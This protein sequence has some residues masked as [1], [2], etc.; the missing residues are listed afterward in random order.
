MVRTCDGV[1]RL[2]VLHVPP[3]TFKSY[4]EKRLHA[5]RQATYQDDSKGNFEPG[6]RVRWDLMEPYASEEDKEWLGQMQNG[7]VPLKLH[8]RPQAYYRAKNYKSYEE[9]KEKGDAE[10]QRMLARG[11][12]EG[13]LHY[14][15]W[16][17]NPM[18]G[19]WK[20]DKGKWRTIHDLTASGVNGSMQVSTCSYDMLD[21]VLKDQETSCYMIGWDV[22]DAFFNQGRRQEH[23]DYMGSESD[24]EFY[25][26]R[27]RVFGV[28]DGPEHQQRSSKLLQ[29]T[30]NAKRES[31]GWPDIRNSG[32]FMDDGHG[33]AR[34]SAPVEDLQHQ[35][36]RMMDYFG[37]L[38]F[39]DSHSKREGPRKVKSHM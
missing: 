26:H 19:I 7:G 12:I 2:L 23:C 8:K 29:T 21:E 13:P 3:R 37:E 11:V 20:P 35:Y 24:G 33:L 34:G 6:V 36:D 25:R 5:K 17:V 18:G 32:V 22:K 28:T 15:P 39:D 30:L 10:M 31:G 27:S 16:V 14:R 9:H 1:H 4:E 38:G